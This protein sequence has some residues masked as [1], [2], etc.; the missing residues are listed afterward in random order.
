[1]NPATPTPTAFKC[2][3]CDGPLTA[4]P[5]DGT[6]LNKGVTLRC[7]GPCDPGCH[8]SCFGH[9]ENPKEAFT[10]LG[11]KYQKFRRND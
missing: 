11:Q 10:I 5:D 9:G 4:Y 1:M 6:N 7:D 3:L 8:E 2:T